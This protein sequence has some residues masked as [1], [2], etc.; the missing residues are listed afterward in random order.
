LV[1]NHIRKGIQLVDSSCA[2]VLWVKFDRHIFDIAFDIFYCVIYISPHNS[3]FAAKLDYCPFEM[4]HKDVEKYRKLGEVILGGD[5]NARTAVSPDYIQ[6]DRG[7]DPIP[8]PSFYD[9]ARDGCSKRNSQDTVINEHG[10]KL[11]SLC[12]SHNLRILNGRKAGDSGGYFTCFKYNG[13]SVVDYALVSPALFNSV[14][15]FN[16][17]NFTP[18]SD[19]CMVSFR[20]LL[21][22][23]R[24]PS[25]S[26]LGTPYVDNEITLE[27]PP[28]KYIWEADSGPKFLKCL[29]QPNITSQ[30]EKFM[31]TKTQ[32]LILVKM[33]LTV[34][35]IVFLIS[36]LKQQMS[37][38][39]KHS[40]QLN[41]E[42]HVHELRK[43]KGG[44]IRT[45]L[46]FTVMLL[47]QLECF[48]KIHLSIICVLTILS[49]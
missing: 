16:V 39:R 41:L 36:S 44:S 14:L 31:D 11:L 46:H 37:A 12:Q 42:I 49:S 7:H 4:L 29:Q 21:T 38:S 1:K 22:D 48:K 30:I 6:H 5:P 2:D 43:R 8:V 19:H 23:F 33:K 34:Q 20:L 24:T 18:F 45:V 28:V 25:V 32:N 27:A 35:L 47:R 26:Q 15:Y 17:E 40:Y 9:D 3:T 13:Q 10:R